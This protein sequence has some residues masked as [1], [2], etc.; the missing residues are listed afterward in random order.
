[1]MAAGR[2][3]HSW[4]SEE[5]PGVEH[6]SVVFFLGETRRRKRDVKQVWKLII[7][8]TGGENDTCRVTLDSA[9]LSRGCRSSDSR[10]IVDD[11][12][13]WTLN[14]EENSVK[15]GGEL[16]LCSYADGPFRM[17]ESRI[18]RIPVRCNCTVDE[19]YRFEAEGRAWPTFGSF[20]V[21]HVGEISGEQRYSLVRD[22]WFARDRFYRCNM[23]G[24]S[25]L[26]S[27]ERYVDYRDDYGGF[28]NAVQIKG[29]TF[30]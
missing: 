27:H 24:K 15:T 8:N 11:E 26:I 6:R 2:R 28:V 23:F 12:W 7:A 13:W 19:D 3:L 14:I 5:K 25:L 18:N 29:R 1:M 22:C 9:S 20:A 4:R 17:R 10:C 16:A 21:D 30:L